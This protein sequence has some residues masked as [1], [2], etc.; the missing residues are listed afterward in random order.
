MKKF[1]RIIAVAGVC[2]AV[3]AGC[4]S[5]DTAGSAAGTEA[6]SETQDSGSETSADAGEGLRDVTDLETQSL[7]ELD[8]DSLVKLGDYK[9]ITIEAAK[10]TITDEDVETTLKSDY[11]AN[12]LKKEVTDRAI[13]DG[14]TANIDFEGKYADTKE[15]FDGGTSQGYDLVIGSHS[16][17][18]GFEDGLIGVNVGETV[19]LN[20]TFPESYGNADLAGKD[21]IFTVKVNSIKKAEEEPSDEWAKS[22]S[23]DD[24]STLDDYRAHLKEEM[25][26]DAQADFDDTVRQQA[27]EIA[28]DNATVDETPQG[29]INRY[30]KM[31]RQ[32]VDSYVQQMAAYTGQQYTAE[33]YVEGVMQNNGLTGTVEDYLSDI[34]TQQAKRCLVLQAIANR[35]NIE[36]T[37]ETIDQYIREDY[38]AYYSQQYATIEEFKATFE[39][40]DYREQVM[41]EKV[42]DFIVE[43]ADVQATETVA[44]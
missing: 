29:L 14:D 8:V 7:S 37:D 36:I 13:Q 31:V 32:S 20:L 26:E 22:L 16:F 41:T 19:D 3:L 25:E 34:A 30:Y 9:G 33:Q 6:S 28:V 5:Q 43:N 2:A 27:V 42:A 18:D 10:K 11:S 24:V 35:E 17:I 15:A 40:E 4:G 44:D 23:L 39:P 21:V 1:Y 12:P 38:D